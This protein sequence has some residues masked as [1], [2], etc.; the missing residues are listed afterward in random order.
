MNG[1]KEKEGGG[2]GDSSRSRA[3][4]GVY[5]KNESAARVITPS[6]GGEPAAAA[7]AR[8]PGGRQED[9][10]APGGEEKL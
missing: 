9:A 10:A 3:R 2:V 8:T 5:G 7:A 4:D 6:L 1:V